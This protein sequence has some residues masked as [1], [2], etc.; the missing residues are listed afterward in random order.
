MAAKAPLKDRCTNWFARRTTN[1]IHSDS[2]RG[3]AIEFTIEDGKYLDNWLETLPEDLKYQAYRMPWPIAA[4]EAGL[5]T[6]VSERTIRRIMH[7]RHD[8]F[9]TCKSTQKLGLIEA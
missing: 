4:A 3:P 9:S 8:S 2:H 6:E 1:N 5:Q 7:S